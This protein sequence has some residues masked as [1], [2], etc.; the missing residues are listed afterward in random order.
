M[1][2]AVVVFVHPGQTLATIPEA[3]SFFQAWH[4]AIVQDSHSS[5]WCILCKLPTFEALQFFPM[6]PIMPHLAL[7]VL[8]STMDPSVEPVLHLDVPSC[9]MDCLLIWLLH[10]MLQHNVEYT[11]MPP[12][13]QHSMSIP[14]DICMENFLKLWQNSIYVTWKKGSPGED[15]G[16]AMT[17][18]TTCRKEYDPRRVVLDISD[19]TTIRY[20]A[21]KVDDDK[22]EMAD[23]DDDASMEDL[24]GDSEGNDDSLDDDDIDDDLQW[25]AL[26]VG[27]KTDDSGFLSGFDDNPRIKVLLGASTC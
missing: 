2:S 19:D 9:D 5:R 12:A 18:I 14:W 21:L 11:I 10:N 4:D 13:L 27:N 16:I 24:L 15:V 20:L 3:V 22:E 26:E 6:I 17:L 25:T 23:S 7:P 8:M 1:Y